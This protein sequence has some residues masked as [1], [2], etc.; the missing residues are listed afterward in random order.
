MNEYPLIRITEEDI[1]EAN[2]LSLNCPICASAVENQTENEAMTPVVC[3]KCQTLYHRACWDLKGGKCAM[4]GCEH[5]ECYPYG[6]TAG[7]L[8]TIQ[9]ADL[10]KDSP[11]LSGNGANKALKA[12]QKRLRERERRSFWGILWRRLLES[13]KLWPS[14]P[15]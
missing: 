4:L 12:E 14:D 15:T 3:G 2:R 13:I 8:L 1:N 7:P 11:R 10:P 9:Y 5:E 6:Q